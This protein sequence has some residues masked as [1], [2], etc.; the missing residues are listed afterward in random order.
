MATLPEVRNVWV[1]VAVENALA[2]VLRFPAVGTTATA[3]PICVLLALKTMLPVGP[4]PI[5]F[6]LTLAVMVTGVA[7][8]MLVAGAAAML[9]VVAAAVT[10]MD[11]AGEV[12]ALKL[13]S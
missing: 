11:F 7:V 8:V 2:P 6:V 9:T 1:I 4:A 5:L 12:L 10:L 13:L 3:L